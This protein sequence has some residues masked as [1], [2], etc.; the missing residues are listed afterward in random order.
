[1]RGP[2]V[3]VGRALCLCASLA[4]AVSAHDDSGQDEMRLDLIHHHQDGPQPKAG[5]EPSAEFLRCNKAA[6]RM[7]GQYLVVLREGTHE[8]HVQRTMRGLRAKAA[9]RGYL[10]EILN[11]Y[12][13]AF[14]GFLVKMNS[15]MLQMAVKLPHVDYIEEDSFIFAQNVPW[16][17][18]RLLQPHSDT[19]DTEKYRPPNA[20]GMAEVYLMDGSVQSSHRE[21]EGQVLVTDFNDVPEEDGVRVHRQD[22]QCDS[23]G[24]HIAG[25]VS[26]WDSGIA[27]GASINQVRVLNC[28]GK[29]T[30]SGAL[31]GMEYI[32]ATLLARPVSSVVV[33]LPFIGGFSR[34]LN[35]ACREM[36]ANRAVV[37]AAAG[38]FRDDACLYSPASEP[39][40]ITIGA[41]NSADQPMSLGAGGTNLGRCVDLFAP[42]DDIVSASSDCSTC[43]TS[44]SGTSQ[45]AAHVAGIAAVI[46]SSSPNA[47]S[48]QILQNLLRYS[49]SNTINPLS[50]AEKHRLTTPNLVAAM[51][52]MATNNTNGE[53][54]CRSVWSDRSGVMTADRAM[55]RCHR[56]EEM[57]GCTS[58]A[59]DGVRMGEAIIENGGQVDCVALNGPG[60]KGVYAVARCC[61]TVGLQCQ[62]HDS[63]EPGK[64]AECVSSH[65]HLTGCSSQSIAEVLPDS[66]PLHSE[67]KRCVG[68]EGMMTSNAVCCHAPQL[69]CRLL[70]H[71]TTDKEQAEVSCPSGWTLTD[72]SAV[73][74]GSALRGPLA[75][76]NS[77]L[78]Q[79]AAGGDGAVGVA[80]CC[81]I[82][83]SQQ[84]AISPQR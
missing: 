21:I 42:G 15:D 32:R 76:G 22:S 51:P 29:G 1:M 47:S 62:V 46:L 25:V 77:C 45:A 82:G 83:Q 44:S 35:A 50:L 31:A 57:M 66:R 36:V 17:L 55:I 6:W 74:R 70:E 43:F 58:Y 3:L 13:G 23:H 69:E 24:T 59:P 80:T 71:I 81:R 60:G 7:P 5:P 26:G 49:V 61:A 64:D 27:R 28:Q 65:H 52:P 37:I 67:P 14:H 30:V 10:L 19:S 12:S 18:Q 84:S 40:V 9:R 68:T 63:P 11:T 38:N 33:L 73:S 2:L 34:S 78:V 16:N 79:S 54:L 56:G 72:C 8:S 48:V 53:L 75:K 41:V 39:E 20:E 4:L